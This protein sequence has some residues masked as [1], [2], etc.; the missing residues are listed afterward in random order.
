MTRRS[1]L[2]FVMLSVL[3]GI[4]YLMIKVAV[5]EVSV[6]FLVFARSVIGAAA[7]VPFAIA[8]RGLGAVGKHWLAVL[9]FSLVEMVVPWGLI[10]HGETSVGSSTAG[11]L[12][13]LTPMVTVVLAAGIGPR[14]AI[15]L[16]R[17]LGLLLGF[18]GVCFLAAPGA[19]GSLLGVCEILAASVCYAVGSLIASRWLKD[20]PPAALSAVCLVIAALAYGGPAALT[21]PASVPSRS[22]LG[23][24]L[25]LGVFCTALA[26]AA[27]FLLI[28][29]VGPERAV[30][31]T[32]VAPAVAVAAGFLV[33]SEPLD[34][35]MLAAFAMILCG[36][37]LA[38]MRTEGERAN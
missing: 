12:I 18:A 6:P 15:G 26:F 22:A 10:A 13:A 29:E 27:F 3:W 38:T 25:T 24:I 1:L 7:L 37:Y 34:A 21:W 8:Q 30:V 31:I 5:A 19:G 35:R 28:R 20:I 33:L 36:S 9:A 11:L 4:P 17:W 16:R 32:Y 2:L 23:A 14:E